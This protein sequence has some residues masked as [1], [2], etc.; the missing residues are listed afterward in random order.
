[1]KKCLLLLSLLAVGNA[2]ALG[3]VGKDTKELVSSLLHYVEMLQGQNEGRFIALGIKK[4]VELVEGVSRD[5][6]DKAKSY[7]LYLLS[8]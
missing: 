3:G 6:S 2:M 7:V 8:K 4:P 1:M 5:L